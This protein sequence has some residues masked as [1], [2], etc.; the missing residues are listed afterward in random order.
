MISRWFGVSFALLAWL[1]VAPVCL[2][3]DI[4]TP[5][6]APAPAASP[7]PAPKKALI[8]VKRASM[9]GLI[10][11][12]S[13]YADKDYSSARDGMGGWSGSNT[14][15]RPAFQATFRYQFSN[16]FRWQI[17]PGYTW[18]GYQDGPMPFRDPYSSADTTTK[19]VLT[20][21]LPLTAQLQFVRSRGDWVYHLGA[22]GGAYRVWVENRRHV[23]ADPVT[24]VR[25]SGFYPGLCAE[26][27][28]ARVLHSLSSVSLEAALDG[29]WVF[30]QRDE[31]FPSGFNSFLFVI[32]AKVGA[33]YHFDPARFLT[34]SPGTGPPGGK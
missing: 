12:S 18:S 14:R 17:S 22:G 10:G 33:N 5:P 8:Y 26:F 7:K 6:P 4:S 1:T 27:G 9:G 3:Q 23:L 20:Q 31:Q 16:W 30:A 13:F 11:W 32:E 15:G 19:E 21:V 25:H 34:K 2:A 24:F 29:H 28:T